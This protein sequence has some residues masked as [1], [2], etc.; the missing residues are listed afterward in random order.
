MLEGRVGAKLVLLV[1]V[2]CLWVSPHGKVHTL[3]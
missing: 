2:V 1:M 3:N